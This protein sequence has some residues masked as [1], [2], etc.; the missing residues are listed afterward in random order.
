MTLDDPIANVIDRL[1]RLGLEPRKAGEEYSCCCPAHKDRSPSLSIGIGSNG[2]AL[3]KCHK[4]CSL[5][6]ILSRLHLEISDLFAEDGATKPRNS[7]PAKK[8]TF[9]TSESALA[10]YGFGEPSA[11][12]HYH[13]AEGE[14]VGAVARWDAVDGKKIRPAS[15][16]GGTWV[17]SAM[18]KPRPIYRLP[19][20]LSAVG[21]IYVAEGEKAADAL[22][23][24]GLTATTSAGGAKAAALTDWSHVAGHEVVVLPDNDTAGEA[25]AT[26]VAGLCH[27]AGAASV[28]I[29][30]LY[31]S[32]SPRD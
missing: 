24:L 6:S 9:A 7:P 14:L 30:L 13:A 20:L 17:L 28:V 15:L 25:Y 22:V 5:D 11:V 2:Q 4:G 8:R 12:W 10:S 23:S 1:H 27:A 19:E 31:T 21:A 18:P 32:P 3:I 26:D 29:C 16:S